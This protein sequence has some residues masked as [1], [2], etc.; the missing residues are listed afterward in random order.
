MFSCNAVKKVGE[1]EFLLT[2]NTVLENGKK[3]GNE[4]INSLLYQK[5]NSS[6]LGFPL[7]LSIHN[8]ARDNRD[9]LYQAWLL[10]K[11]KRLERLTKKLS[12]KQVRELG[13]YAVGFNN[14]L[15]KTGEAP[16]IIDPIK[17]KKTKTR[18]KSYYD[19]NGFF[20]SVVTDT[21][22]PSDREK[23]AAIQYRIN[24]GNPYFI[25]SISADITSKEIDSVYRSNNAE[26]HIK[27][28]AQYKNTDFINEQNRLFALFK[29]SG[30]Y[31]FQKNSI[32]F[33]LAADTVSGSEDHK[34]NSEL[35]II[36]RT[37]RTEDSTITRPYKIHTIKNVN[38]Y[39]DTDSRILR[40]AAS[41]TL[42][43][44]NYRLFYNNK[45]RFRPKALTD[46]T[47]IIPGEIYSD[48]DRA[49]TFRSLNN[50]QTFK[51]PNI[52]YEYID[53]TGT[54]LEAN[55]FLAPRKKFSVRFDVDLSHSDIQDFGVSFL[56]AITA[57]NVFRGAE[58]MQLALRGT[59]GSTNDPA[60]NDNR[61]FNILEVGGDL[62][63]DFPRFFFPFDTE[64]V[65]PKYMLP[66]TQISLGISLQE[67]IGLDRQNFTTILRYNW[68]PD[69][70]KTNNF[71]LLNVQF[72]NN[73]N[74]ANY[75]GIYQNSYNELNEI[76][77]DFNLANPNVITDDLDQDGNLVIPTGA[78]NFIAQVQ[79]G[80]IVLSDL[81]TDDVNTI[82]ERKTRLTENNLIFGSSY[83]YTKNNREGF[84]DNHFSQFRTKF[85]AVG[86]LL[87]TVS[88]LFDFEKDG[89]QFRVFDVAYSQYVK[90]DIDY[91]KYWRLSSSDA[92]AFRT[93]LGLAVPY[94]NSDNIPFSR[95]Y[96]AGG[97]NDN[98][99]WQ[100]YSLGPGS[101]GSPNEFNEAN[102]KFALN[103]EYRF[104]LF[105]SFN[106]ALFADAGNIW[107]VF[108][109]VTDEA[110]TFNGFSS[111]EEIALGTGF[112]IRYDLS[113][114]VL[115][116]DTGFKTYNPA[117]PEN[118]RW[119]KQFNFKN[120]VFNIGINYPF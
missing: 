76:A 111:L 95:S 37:I 96:F 109:D 13:N 67:N 10:R 110:S 11:P 15:R 40:E 74:V 82:E 47:F 112:G 100:A 3:I 102:L 87:S 120:A 115:R 19:I 107:N 61:F 12:L 62:K 114:F 39:T 57:R 9:S 60:N 92:L 29:N 23:R 85:E 70:V 117:L 71:D 43:D 20:N 99:A 30:F 26:S 52:E 103:L 5:P 42:T 108:D 118:E 14:W 50:L 54:N 65:I 89:D 34:I 86:N 7:R 72:V 106:G 17:T 101:S 59:L 83:T 21:L 27:T 78:N 18:L 51:Y 64:K 58:T 41:D 38:I 105:G 68:K 119:F 79:N 90:T 56:G 45:L 55:I 1:N 33:E 88:G 53:S 94:G 93:F 31:T 113:F 91:I 36:D 104:N 44:N 25:D 28:G 77:Q 97:S 98:R 6:I 69:L 16:V 35:K 80:S 84:L 48:K 24:T 75:F 66:T 2:K 8:L 4:E 73:K 116:L 81:E 46:A 63:I 32:R 49:Q 22:I